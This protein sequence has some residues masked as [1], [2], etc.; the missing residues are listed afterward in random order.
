M[1]GEIV[2][3]LEKQAV[4]CWCRCHLPASHMALPMMAHLRGT[5]TV[6]LS[7]CQRTG[8]MMQ[9]VPELDQCSGLVLKVHKRTTIPPVA[10]LLLLL[11][12]ALIGLLGH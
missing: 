2:E 10:K 9:S 1:K 6:V 4:P 12:P 11:D 3:A 8:E 7:Y 5:S